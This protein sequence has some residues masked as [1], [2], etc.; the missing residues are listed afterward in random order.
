MNFRL[1]V[2]VALAA[3]SFVSI[4]VSPSRS[5][6]PRKPSL[7]AGPTATSPERGRAGSSVSGTGCGRMAR[8]ENVST[9]R[10]SDGLYFGQ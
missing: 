8:E 7:E 5:D 2:F 10:V 4:A 1:N 6:E 9:I 3:L